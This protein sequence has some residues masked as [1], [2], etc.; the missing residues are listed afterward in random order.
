MRDDARKENER[1]ARAMQM[2][3]DQKRGKLLPKKACDVHDASGRFQGAFG[4]GCI[5]EMDIR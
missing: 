1:A 5:G 3:G 4:S 2:L